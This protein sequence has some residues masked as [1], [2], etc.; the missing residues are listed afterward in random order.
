MSNNET[1]K[2]EP[3]ST[4]SVIFNTLPIPEKPSLDIP[5]NNLDSKK[6]QT[7]LTNDAKKN[8]HKREQI[9]ESAK[10]Y[11]TAI[12]IAS[13][14]PCFILLIIAWFFCCCLNSIEVKAGVELAIKAIITLF[15]GG[16]IGK[17]L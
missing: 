2:T 6:L 13:I 12:A 11:S 17:H 5:T 16:L 1:I 14:L 10:S 15:I 9:I 3:R 4:T 8:A 7:E